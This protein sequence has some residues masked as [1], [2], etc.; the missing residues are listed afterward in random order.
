MNAQ[1]TIFL[2]NGEKIDEITNNQYEY[3]QISLQSN[4]LQMSFGA[5]TKQSQSKNLDQLLI[6]DAS[7]LQS[8]TFACYLDQAFVP[9]KMDQL[10]IPEINSLRISP[11][12]GE[13]LQFSDFIS[14]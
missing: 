11:L 5:G 8:T 3:Y 7:N 10:F 14:I 2:D 12:A 6:T 4:S 1:G 9:H 13:N